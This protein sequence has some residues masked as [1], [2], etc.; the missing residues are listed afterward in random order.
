MTERPRVWV[1]KSAPAPEAV[2][3]GWPG[4]DGDPQ[5]DGEETFWSS[6][7]MERRPWK[8]NEKIFSLQEKLIFGSSTD[9]FFYLN[10]Y[11]K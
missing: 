10:C 4:P 11:L 2:E 3:E 6:K 8:E 9:N 7:D 5:E 1:R